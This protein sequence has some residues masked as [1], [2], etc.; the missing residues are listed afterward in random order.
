MTSPAERAARRWAVAVAALAVVAALRCWL[1]RASVPDDADALGFVLGMSRGYD[2]ALLQP[3]FP[4]YPVY[5]ALGAALVRAGVPALDAATALSAIASGIASAALALCA[6]R[7]AGPAAGLGAAAL[8]AAAFLPWLVGGAAL[9]DGLGTALAAWSFAALA[10]ERPRP[11]VAALLAG[12]TLGVRASYWPLGAVALALAWRARGELRGRVAAAFAGGVSAWAVPFVALVGAGPLVALGK[13]HLAGHF[14]EWGGSIAT[15][16]ELGERLVAFA[17]GAAFDGLAPSKYGLAL[18]AAL[19]AGTGLL[20]WHR[21]RSMPVR[22]FAV[23][24][25]A[26]APYAL[27]ALLAQ[28][29]LAQPR[30]LLPLAEGLCVA[31]GAWLAPHRLALLAVLGVMA[32]VA[33]PLAWQRHVVP[34]APAQAAAW[35]VAN[36]PP[37]DALLFAGRSGRYLHEAAPALDVRERAWLSEAAADLSRLDRVPAAV[38]V[39]SEV[40]LRTGG[41]GWRVEP[42]PVFCRDPRL[43]RALPCLGLSR[44]AWSSP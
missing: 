23:L 11:V 15:R 39:T 22:P 17:R 38:Y 18:I 32:V 26:L 30:H 8:H 5:V 7:L 4:G 10:L 36:T 12:V 44:L 20:D 14:G 42:G 41:G 2:L 40:D 6:R 9:S 3:H 25:A 31:L 27:W 43:D 13:T 37:D 34:P 29:V 21:R 35:L 19:L 33:A 28:N 1:T 24:A 16:P